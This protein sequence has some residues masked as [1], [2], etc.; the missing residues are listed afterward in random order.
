MPLEAGAFVEAMTKKPRQQSFVLTQ[1][2]NAIAD[3]A[4]RKHVEFFAEASA[5]AAI[6]TDGHH[7]GKITDQERIVPVARRVRGSNEPLQAFQ[8]SGKTG[9][10]TDG[11]DP[12]TA[13]RGGL[14]RQTGLGGFG[15]HRDYP[16]ELQRFLVA[17][18]A[19]GRLV[20]SS[21]IRVKEF[22]EARILSQILKVGIVACLK[23]QG[24]IQFQ[25]F[26][27]TSQ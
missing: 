12:E 7:G 15:F 2:N 25:R 27:Q 17:H 13:R 4:R 21:G 11:D 6:V 9:A 26:I 10:A 23:A 16:D 1:G 19:L 22:R 24:G 8:K 18:G 3:V 14:L 5:G 20:I